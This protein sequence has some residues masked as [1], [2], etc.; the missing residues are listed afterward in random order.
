MTFTLAEF[1]VEKKW[2]VTNCSLLEFLRQFGHSTRR[3]ILGGLVFTPCFNMSLL[4]PSKISVYLRQVSN[5]L[6]LRTTGGA[7]NF[8][9]SW[10]PPLRL[11]M[12]PGAVAWA[13]G[14]V[15]TTTPTQAILRYRK[16]RDTLAAGWLRIDHRPRCH[17]CAAQKVFPESETSF[18][19]GQR[20]A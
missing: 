19:R 7:L 16:R 14:L 20:Q 4:I 10:V 15:A 11:G 1:L 8:P 17:H 6:H 9:D 12:V 13:S 18:P 3:T 5:W 2:K